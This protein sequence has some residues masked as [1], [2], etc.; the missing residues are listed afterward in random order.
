MKW[1]VILPDLSKS[2][3]YLQLVVLQKEKPLSFVEVPGYLPGRET[4]DWS[5]V[6]C[7]GGVLVLV[8]NLSRVDCT[9]VPE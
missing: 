2:L 8:T 1:L 4:I 7:G 9:K 3:Q 5:L 6:V